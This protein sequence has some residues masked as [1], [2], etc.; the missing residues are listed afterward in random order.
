MHSRSL[1]R[2]AF[3]MRGAIAAC[4][5]LFFAPPILAGTP[6]DWENEQVLEINRQPDRATFVHYPDVASALSGAA[7]PFVLS[8]NGSW[9]FS[10]GAGTAKRP[11]DSNMGLL[12]VEVRWIKDLK[13]RPQTSDF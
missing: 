2:E 8:L 4:L 3:G 5:I 12:T 1:N 13:R 10:L 9:R 11:G 7:S 6:P